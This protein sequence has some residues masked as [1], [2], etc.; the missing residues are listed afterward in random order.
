MH[1]YVMALIPPNCY[2]EKFIEEIMKKYDQNREVP[3]Y[4]CKCDLC[5]DRE[6]PDPECNWC[7][8]TGI[9]K[10]TFNP[11]GH[12]DYYSIGGRWDGSVCDI[13][14]EGGGT[15]MDRLSDNIITVSRLKRD[16]E[17]HPSDIVTHRSWITLGRY[18]KN[19]KWFSF[20]DNQ[21]MKMINTIYDTYADFQAVGL[22][23]HV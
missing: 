7:K 2:A 15:P 18:H 16:L 4:E 19:R 6:K 11:H 14:W 17:S 22:D 23:C 20:S 12:W 3:E 13:T 9:N 21:R 5:E 1:S 8:G 10:T